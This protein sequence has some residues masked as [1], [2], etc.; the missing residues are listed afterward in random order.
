MEARLLG[1]TEL[2][3]SRIGF[4]TWAVGGGN[5]S[6]GW[7]DQDDAE[8]LAAIH[9]ALE[10]GIN[11]IDTAAVYGLGHAED[12]VRTALKQVG[13][14]RRPHVFTK[15]GL[16]WDEQGNVSH[17]L[18]ADSIRREVEASLRRLQVDVIDLYQIHW[19]AF[20]VGGPDPDLE[21]AWSTLAELRQAGKV[22]YIAVSNF[23]A[24][25]LERIR[26]IAPVS[27]N[28]P[29]YSILRR[30][31]EA[32]VLPYCAEHK[33]GVIIYSPMQS[34]LLTG[35]MTPER[36]A[37]LPK[38]DWRS[39]SPAFQEPNLRRNLRL[40]EVLRGIGQRHGCS[41]GEVAIAWT[42]RHPAVT[43]AIVG[44]RHPTQVDGFIGSASVRLT[45]ADLAEI[46][47]VVSA[48]EAGS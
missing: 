16:V 44:G 25:Q 37:A 17:C 32:D 48:T 15:C 43:G 19:P 4:G 14:S 42:L 7:G 33:V 6:H 23:D 45:E 5:W 13:S 10:L 34:G 28:Q 30:G 1:N 38:N 27:S 36:I 39:R 9:R 18:K 47:G 40:V 21:E 35:R 3:I 29:P 12:V 2:R 41:P 31:I 22:R 8:S 26:K 46:G 20:P 24:T 11:W